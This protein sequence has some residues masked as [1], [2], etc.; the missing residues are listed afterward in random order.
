MILSRKQWDREKRIKQMRRYYHLSTSFRKKRMTS[1]DSPAIIDTPLNSTRRFKFPDKSDLYENEKE[2]FPQ[3][4]L[5]SIKERLTINEESPL[6]NEDDDMD[7][8]FGFKER[9]TINHQHRTHPVDSELFNMKLSPSMTTMEQPPNFGINKKKLFDPKDSSYFQLNRENIKNF[10]INGRIIDDANEYEIYNVLT[11]SIDESNKK[12]IQVNFCM[13]YLLEESRIILKFSDLSFNKQ[14]FLINQRKLKRNHL[15]A[16]WSLYVFIH[17][18]K[19]DKKWMKICELEDF[20]KIGESQIIVTQNNRIQMKVD[21]EIIIDNISIIDLYSRRLKIAIVREA[22]S[23]DSKSYLQLKKK[24]IHYSIDI[25]RPSF[26]LINK[27]RNPKIA[28]KNSMNDHR[29]S[30]S[31]SRQ[32]FLSD[33]IDVID[34]GKNVHPFSL[35]MEE[36]KISRFLQII[37]QSNERNVKMNE[38]NNNMN[39]LSSVWF[40]FEMWLKEKNKFDRTAPITTIIQQNHYENIDCST[41]SIQ[42]F[43]KNY[44]YLSISKFQ[45]ISRN[46]GILNP[47]I[48]IDMELCDRLEYQQLTLDGQHMCHLNQVE[49]CKRILIVSLIMTSNFYPMKEISFRLYSLKGQY[50]NHL[51]IEDM[52]VNQFDPNL[53]KFF[54]IFIGIDQPNLFDFS[55]LLLFNVNQMDRRH[56]QK[57]ISSASINTIRNLKETISENFNS[58]I[59]LNSDMNDGEL[60]K[61]WENLTIFPNESFRFWRAL[62]AIE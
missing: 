34:Q 44:N 51:K 28:K 26:N 4:N 60:R 12:D 17:P 29:L 58:F 40:P 56:N 37:H 39:N 45:I 35:I 33:N 30:E 3:F 8:I 13:K 18:H 41:N 5:Q 59:F 16:F 31:N 6:N 54:K 9:P 47:Y 50:H 43:I 15:V 10:L 19:S 46:N 20:E 1:I 24:S 42:S 7:V 21:K 23:R 11:N 55:L 32:I 62:E 61:H 52:A 53:R 38:N 48:L 49:N 2:M 14:Y 25:H 36:D 57:R 27:N 22:K